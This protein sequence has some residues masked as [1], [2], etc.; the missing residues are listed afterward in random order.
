MSHSPDQQKEQAN[1]TLT[2][3]GK[4]TF[5]VRG[6]QPSLQGNTASERAVLHT[7]VQYNA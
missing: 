2:L 4:M 7:Y 6:F 1:K 5:F 3:Y